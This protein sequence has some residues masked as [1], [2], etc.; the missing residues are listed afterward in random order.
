MSELIRL[1]AGDNLANWMKL[2]LQSSVGEG[3][4]ARAILAAHNEIV[5]LQRATN[6]A[7]DTGIALVW[8]GD[9]PIWSAATETG[10]AVVVTDDDETSGYNYYAWLAGRGDTSIPLATC[11]PTGCYTLLGAK[12]WC[13]DRLTGLHEAAQ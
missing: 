11:G 5:A 10:W 12:A 9:D 1:D 7:D 13:S 2:V 8:A 6:A 4:E 3:P